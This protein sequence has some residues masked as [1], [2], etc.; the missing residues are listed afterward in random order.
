MNTRLAKSSPTER[1][2]VSLLRWAARWRLA[3]LLLEPPAANWSSE[4]LTLRVE[5]DD[6]LLNE[7]VEDALRHAAQATYHTIFG[8]GGPVSLREVTYRPLSDPGRLLAE[9]RQLYQLF[10]YSPRLSESPDHLAVETGFMAYLHFKQAFAQTLAE[11]HKA[12]A[13]HQTAAQFAGTHLVAVARPVAD[14][15]AKLDVQFLAQAVKAVA[16]WAQVLADT[17]PRTAESIDTSAGPLP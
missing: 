15:L 7:A 14:S 1:A 17:L 9:L 10:G 3:A 12:N 5:A 4:L 13:I 11:S 16:D 6:P 2:A 8:P